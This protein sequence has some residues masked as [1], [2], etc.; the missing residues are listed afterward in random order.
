M[1]LQVETNLTQLIKRISEEARKA[2]K[3]ADVLTGVVTSTSPFQV[4]I[5]ARLE[6]TEDFLIITQTAKDNAAENDKVL[7]ISQEGGQRYAVVDKV[8]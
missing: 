7:L 5:S 3:P 1:V 8:V 2:K 6:L 4:R